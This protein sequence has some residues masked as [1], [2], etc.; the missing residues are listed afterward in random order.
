[1]KEGGERIG[2]W[3]RDEVVVERFKE[4]EKKNERSW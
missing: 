4:V 2:A 3:S 1:M